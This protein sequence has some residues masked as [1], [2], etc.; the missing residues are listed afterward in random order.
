M[1]SLYNNQ[2]TSANYVATNQTN[3]TYTVDVNG[4]I[5][6]V[7]TGYEGMAIPVSGN[8]TLSVIPIVLKLPSGI[9]YGV[10]S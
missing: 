4:M 10:R 6:Q 2:K 5:T 7:T 1:Y 9:L 3:G 8:T